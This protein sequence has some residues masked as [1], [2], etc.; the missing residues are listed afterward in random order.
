VVIVALGAAAGTLG[1]VTLVR[2]DPGLPVMKL[3]VVFALVGIGVSA[4][5]NVAALRLALSPVRNLEETAKRVRDGNVDARVP[6]SPFADAELQLL[7]QTFN[8]TLTELASYRHRVRAAAATALRAGEA[9]RKRIAQELHDDT[10]STLTALL[11]RL[12]VA[13]DATSAAARDRE[14]EEVRNGLAKAIDTIHR[15][16]RALRPAALDKMGVVTAI[17]EH[18]RLLRET[19]DLH[20]QVKADSI[21]GLLSSDAELALYR[22]VQEALSNAVRHAESQTV[23]I[24]V[25]RQP[26]GVHAIVSDN[27]R[28]FTISEERTGAHRGLGLLGM[29]ERAA[30]L[31]G[32]VRITS[33]PGAGTVVRVQI[34]SRDTV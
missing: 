5:T 33:R 17:E 28:G 27:G 24:R 3:V 20:M 11:V 14:L 25:E 29:Q 21:D 30:Y 34:P 10:A 15:I 1:T 31:G 32:R 6:P 7:S 13:R 19:T 23:R 9:E 12:R 26:D 4:V 8:D 18:V 2:A 22:I 16:A